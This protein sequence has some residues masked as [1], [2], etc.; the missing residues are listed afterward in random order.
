MF[1][2]GFTE[3]YCSDL[4]ASCFLFLSFLLLSE[5]IIHS[6]VTYNSFSEIPTALSLWRSLCKQIQ[7]LA[8]SI[9]FSYLT[10]TF[11]DLI[12]MPTYVKLH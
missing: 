12:I 10:L 2:T 5:H 6:L 1:N 7:K 9:Y 8:F 4:E 11:L 3:Y